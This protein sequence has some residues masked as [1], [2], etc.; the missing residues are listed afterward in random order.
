MSVTTG[1]ARR[2]VAGLLAALTVVGTT[3]ACS[4]KDDNAEGEG[5]VNLVVQTFGKFGYDQAIKDYEAA[6]PNVKVDH[7]V[8]GELSDFQPKLVQWLAAGKGAGDVVALEE[9][10]LL[11]YLQ[12]PDNFVN[13][14]DLGGEEL[15]DKYL[16]WKFERGITPDGKKLV[17]LGTDVGGLAMCYRRDLLEKAGMPSDRTEVAK[18]WATWDDYVKAGQQFK[19]K[20]TGAAWVDSA[21][22]VAQP[23]AMQNG[24]KIFYDTDGS[25]IGDSNPLVKQTWDF[26]TNLYAQGLTAKLKTWSEDWSAGFKKGS[27]ATMPCP[28]WMTGVIESNA[29]PELKGKWDVATIPGGAGNWGGSYLAIPARAQNPAAAWAYIKEMQSPQKQLDH[30]V[31][32]GSLP[33]TPSVYSDPRLAT[34]ADPFFSGAPTGKIYTQAV[35]GLKPFRMGPDTGTIGQEFLNV[36]VNVEQSGGNPATAWDDAVRNIHTAIGK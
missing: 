35:L 29:G 30:F 28:A 14:F 8:L 24:D 13:L 2:V 19:A 27:F 31:E 25:F 32:V 3:A 18:L 12:N 10:V 23:Y 5:K 36:L 15:R 22:S 33:T 1:R 7:Q 16:G 6:N 9:G 26:A 34:K 20:N 11:G 17:G 21:G 4:K